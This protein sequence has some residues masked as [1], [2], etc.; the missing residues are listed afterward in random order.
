MSTEIINAIKEEIELLDEMSQ[1]HA[2]QKE[3]A[4]IQACF[5]HMRRSYMRIIDRAE[6]NKK[7]EFKLKNGELV[8][9]RSDSQLIS[10]D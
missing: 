2:K 5:V 7:F 3:Y 6:N 10:V 9:I 8:I 1:Y 4:F